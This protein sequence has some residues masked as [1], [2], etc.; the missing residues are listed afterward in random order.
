MRGDIVAQFAA[1]LRGRY[2]VKV[3]PRA[4]ESL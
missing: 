2:S 3:N 1:G 4:L